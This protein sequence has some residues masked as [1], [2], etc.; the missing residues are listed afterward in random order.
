MA[1]WFGMSARKFDLAVTGF[2][3]RAGGKAWS[4]DY[5]DSR[6]WGRWVVGSDYDQPAGG[7]SRVNTAPRF[8]V[9]PPRPPSAD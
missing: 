6:R 8:G 9:G 3:E 4:A 5:T 7:G 1:K 2:L